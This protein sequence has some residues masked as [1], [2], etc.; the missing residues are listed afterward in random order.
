LRAAGAAVFPAGFFAT[1]LRGAA[2]RPARFAAATVLDLAG[3]L[4]T[5]FGGFL[6]MMI[7]AIRGSRAPEH[8]G[9]R[10]NLKL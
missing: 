8:W 2:V 4:R 6:A 5:G 9:I 3:D 7:L 1:G 10:E